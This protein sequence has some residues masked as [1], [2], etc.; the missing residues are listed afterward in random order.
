MRVTVWD[1][2]RKVSYLSKVVSDRKIV[3][4]FSKSI[5]F[6]RIGQPVLMMDVKVSKDKNISRWLAERTSSILDETE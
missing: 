6:T 5:S 1:P 4:E 3:T 2:N